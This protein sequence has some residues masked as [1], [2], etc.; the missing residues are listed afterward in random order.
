[1][2]RRGCSSVLSTYSVMVRTRSTGNSA[3]MA[4]TS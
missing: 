3:S 2:L 1:M 4:A